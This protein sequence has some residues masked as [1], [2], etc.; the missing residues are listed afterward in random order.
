MPADEQREQ[1]VPVGAL[2]ER[3]AAASGFD[4][5]LALWRYETVSADRPV[6]RR[7]VRAGGGTVG[8][9]GAG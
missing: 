8:R 9:V 5:A 2:R 7:P 3:L 1:L 6:P 4:R